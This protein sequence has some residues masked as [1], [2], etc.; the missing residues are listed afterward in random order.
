MTEDIVVMADCA[1]RIRFWSAGATRVFGHPATQMLGESLEAIIPPE[2]RPTHR[3]GFQRAM[4]QGHAAAE[5]NPGP[6]PVLRADGTII[7]L[8]GRLTLLRGPAGTVIAAAVVYEPA[9]EPG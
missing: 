3:Q 5:G 8:D 1:G 9:G 6:F 7:T 2:Y 4:M